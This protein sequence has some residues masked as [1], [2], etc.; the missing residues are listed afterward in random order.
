[1]LNSRDLTCSR[2]QPEYFFSS[3]LFIQ[4][5]GGQDFD[6]LDYVFYIN[7]VANLYSGYVPTFND[8][9]LNISVNGFFNLSAGD[10]VEMFIY[11]DITSS[12]TFNINQDNTTRAR[13][14]WYGYKIIE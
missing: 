7:G 2:F 6:A 4:A 5:A 13:C 9:A 12:G 1:M 3:I 11:G 8:T 14:F 10:Y